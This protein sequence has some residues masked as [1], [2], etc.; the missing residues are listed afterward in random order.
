MTV[1]RS[2]RAVQESGPGIETATCAVCAQ[3]IHRKITAWEH[4]TTGPFARLPV[5]HH[6]T[7][8]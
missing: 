5:R 4:E 6:A 2:P 3:P 1:I 7:P 8:D